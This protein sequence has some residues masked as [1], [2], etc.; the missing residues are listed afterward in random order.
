MTDTETDYRRPTAAVRRGLEAIVHLI[1]GQ[2]PSIEVGGRDGFMV[3]V[4][5]PRDQM[6][7][8]IGA[9]GKTVDALKDAAEAMAANTGLDR[10]KVTI[11]D[12]SVNDIEDGVA[13]DVPD[14]T[15]GEI[16]E[17]FRQFLVVAHGPENFAVYVVGSGD[18][19]TI[20]INL[21]GTTLT[22]AVRIL[23]ECAATGLSRNQGSDGVRH[24][25]SCE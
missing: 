3:A 6:R 24:S 8:I 14:L 21:K 10:V 16:E 20:S 25:L 9:K 18:S 19:K 23:L 13:R 5:V 12:P 22:P 4:I 15:A 11:N 17:L 1:T 7:H 2:P